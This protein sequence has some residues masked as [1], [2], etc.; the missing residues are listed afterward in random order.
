MTLPHRDRQV[1]PHVEDRVGEDPSR[2]LDREILTRPA[3]KRSKRTD[4]GHRRV[5]DTNV[6]DPLEFIAARISGIDRLGVIGAWQAVEYDLI[7]SPGEHW[8]D[9]GG[10]EKILELLY[11]RAAELE[12]NGGR[13]EQLKHRREI[14]LEDEPDDDSEEIVWRHTKDGCGSTDVDQESSMAWYCNDCQQ[15]TNR[16][17]RVETR[18]AVPA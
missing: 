18:E 5:P 4:D 6:G 17:E 11:D 8:R 10:R 16:V 14:V 3:I 15:R 7:R 1:Y 12:A 2:F 9:Q 13:E